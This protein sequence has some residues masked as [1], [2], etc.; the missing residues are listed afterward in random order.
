MT[1]ETFRWL[2]SLRAPVLLPASAG[3]FS[4]PKLAGSRGAWYLRAQVS[5][6]DC[7][8]YT[9]DFSC[10][11]EVKHLPD[12]LS[13]ADWRDEV[14]DDRHG[15]YLRVRERDGNVLLSVSGDGRAWMD[16]ERDRA[17]HPE[18][19]TVYEGD[20]YPA[21]PCGE[22]I[23]AQKPEDGDADRDRAIFDIRDF[24]AV[25][26]R[27][28]L[29]TESIQAAIDAASDVSGTVLVRGGRFMAGTLYLKS[30][31]T[32][33]VDRDAQLVASRQ[34]S[35]LTDAFIIARDAEDVTVTGGGVIDG[36]GEYFVHLPLRRPLLTPLGK[37]KVPPVLYDNMGYPVDTIRY[38]YRSRIRYVSDPYGNGDGVFQRPMYFVWFRNCRN[39]RVN[40]I[41]LRDACDWSL[42]LDGCTGADVSDT[43]IDDNRHVANTDGIDIMASEDVTIRHCFISSADDGI[44]V[45]APKIHEHDGEDIEDA[46][47]T[48]RPTR[49]VFISDCTVSSVM[50][51]FKIG[52]ETYYDI[53]DITVE[54]CRFL[55]PD[56][57]PGMVSGISIESCDG[58]NVENVTVRNIRMEQVVCPV[59]IQL[60]RRNKFGF[61]SE[62]DRRVRENGG[63]I[64]HIRIEGI[65][66][67]DAELPSVVTGFSDGE[68]I[69]RRV[70][71]I[72]L[73]GLLVRYRDNIADLNPQPH[74][75]E[76]VDQYPESNALGDV[77]ASAL[78]VRH[79]DNVKIQD[80]KAWPR[81]GE[82]R[83]TVCTEDVRG[84]LQR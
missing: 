43:V 36:S 11:S 66:S 10:I 61:A 19:G 42:A 71:D 48:M 63:S 32:L 57:A 52:T 83:E 5:G 58:S 24:G 60:N 23:R 12:T 18:C 17:D 50:N 6:G 13:D 72:T 68:G 74:T 51:G 33:F 79:A 44:C 2:S 38:A 76:N 34:R 37:T 30:G 78:F 77:P 80:F 59:F 55:L 73:S 35:R 81:T 53:S 49:R 27:H 16:F 31:V 20:Y 25:P 47:G 9:E 70:E 26:D 41:I 40:N 1:N 75:A 56:I 21:L 64:R 67:V 46:G 29:C 8:F 62:E 7:F 14:R 69:T 28:F 65:D 54:N 15:F 45:K 22:Y 84:I 4:C 39:V 82:K 3:P